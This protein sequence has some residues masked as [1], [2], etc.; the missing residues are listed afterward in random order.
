MVTSANKKQLHNPKEV[1]TIFLNTSV[2]LGNKWKSLESLPLLCAQGKMSFKVSLLCL[3]GR[4]THP[5]HT[6]IS[7]QK[8]YHLL[9]GCSFTSPASVF[10]SYWHQQVITNLELLIQKKITKIKPK[11]INHPT[12]KK[13]RQEGPKCSY[14]KTKMLSQ[15][16]WGLNKSLDLVVSL[17]GVK[18]CSY[19]ANLKK[20]SLIVW[21]QP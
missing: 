6:L 16:W 2:C 3:L 14:L 7:V 15:H 5:K 18:F 10:S 21:M 12:R 11:P 1:R 19:T 17:Q 13:K 8:S 9:T 4:H 20:E